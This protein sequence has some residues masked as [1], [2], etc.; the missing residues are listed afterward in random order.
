[1]AKSIICIFNFFQKIASFMTR[2]NLIEMVEPPHDKLGH[3][4]KKIFQFFLD[5]V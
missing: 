2:P 3:A 5:E 1:M 4:I